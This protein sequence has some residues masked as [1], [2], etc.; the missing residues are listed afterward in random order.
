M[1]GAGHE[2]ADQHRDDGRDRGRHELAEAG[3]DAADERADE[4]AD[5]GEPHDDRR[6]VGGRGAPDGDPGEE[7]DGAEEPRPVRQHRPDRTAID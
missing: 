1:E 6:R 4:R 7:L 3:G 2:D 5:D